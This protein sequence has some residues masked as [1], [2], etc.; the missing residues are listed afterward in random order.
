MTT[1]LAPGQT[2]A[3]RVATVAGRR[4]LLVRIRLMA[5]LPTAALRRTV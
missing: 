1:T 2:C 4:R 5:A 3:P